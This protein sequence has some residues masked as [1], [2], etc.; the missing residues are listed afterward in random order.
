ME[1]LRAA[2]DGQDWQGIEFEPWAPALCLMRLSTC[3][4]N[5]AVIIECRGLE[6]LLP[7]LR[8]GDARTQ[9]CVARVLWHL[10]FTDDLEI[11]IPTIREVVRRTAWCC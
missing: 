3:D 2:A 6:P 5:R 10:A 8:T 1:A 4:A 11:H 9:E 7:L